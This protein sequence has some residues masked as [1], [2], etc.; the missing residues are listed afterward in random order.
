[1][2]PAAELV[3]NAQI[4]R[5]MRALIHG[6]AG[7]PG[8]VAVQLA[9]DAGLHVIATASGDGVALVRPLGADEVITAIFVALIMLFATAASAV[10]MLLWNSV[11]IQAVGARPIGI[12]QALGLLLLCRILFG[13][14]S[15]PHRFGPGSAATREREAWGSMSSEHRARFREHWRVRRSSDP[16][17]KNAAD[18]AR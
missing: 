17:Q 7:A 6:G 8:S 13:A 10:V 18:D 16:S 12:W 1:M 2:F 15:R 14:W 3:D 5:G 9:K 11:V 4:A